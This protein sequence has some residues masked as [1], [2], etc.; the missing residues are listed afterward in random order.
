LAARGLL[1]QLPG[2]VSLSTGYLGYRLLKLAGWSDAALAGIY[3]SSGGPEGHPGAPLVSPTTNPRFRYQAS[4]QEDHRVTATTQ[5]HPAW[6]NADHCP[7][8]EHVSHSYRVA[9]AV[10]LVVEVLQ[11][12]KEPAPRVSIL[13]D[14]GE[15][16]LD[17]PVQQARQL[18]DVLAHV[19]GAVLEGAPLEPPVPVA[20]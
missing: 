15:R 18:A 4:R 9:G 17:M 11:D 16:V 14:D 10:S 8:I 13:E 7:R 12:R 2:Q 19:S 1:P 3:A 20:D 6:C 5:Q